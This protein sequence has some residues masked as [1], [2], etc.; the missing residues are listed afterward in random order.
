MIV[1]KLDTSIDD[2]GRMVDE[3]II[4][5]PILALHLLRANRESLGNAAVFGEIFFASVLGLSRE[6]LGRLT[7][8]D[9]AK[10]SAVINPFLASFSRPDLRQLG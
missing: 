2:G 3:L 10:V 7:L 9:Y 6:A 5:T 4:E 8:E 1:I